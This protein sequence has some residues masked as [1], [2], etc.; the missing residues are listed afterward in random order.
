MLEEWL[1]LNVDDYQR[2]SDRFERYRTVAETLKA[3]GRLYAC[4]KTPEELEFKRKRQMA[5]GLP[6]IY[7][8]AA[9]ELTDEEKQQ[10]DAPTD[11]NDLIRGPIHVEG[12]NLSDPVLIREDGFPI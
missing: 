8:R 2:Q 3:S 12:S 1:G 7:D 11:W 4:Y 5:K 9:L 10:F 6:P